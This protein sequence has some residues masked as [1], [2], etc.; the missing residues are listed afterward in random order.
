MRFIALTI[1]AAAALGVVSRAAESGVAVDFQGF[2]QLKQKTRADNLAQRFLNTCLRWPWPGT[3]SKP[4][5]APV[6]PSPECEQAVKELVTLAVQAEKTAEEA[7]ESATTA[8]EKAEIANSEAQVAKTDAEKALQ[9][10][11]TSEQPSNTAVSHG[12]KTNSAKP[13]DG[14]KTNPAKPEE[15]GA[16]ITATLSVFV[17]LIPALRNLF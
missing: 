13:E 5:T 14:K 2:A 9:T 12:K 17:L 16:P 8:V 7:K 3:S 4:A 15:S 10:A 1:I 6:A 11:S